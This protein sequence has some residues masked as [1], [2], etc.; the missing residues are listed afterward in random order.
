MGKRIVGDELNGTGQYGRTYTEPE[1]T[2][3][4]IRGTFRAYIDER[5]RY[6]ARPSVP[7]SPVEG[8][9]LKQKYRG[10]Y[11]G[12]AYKRCRFGCR[13]DGGNLTRVYYPDGCWVYP[14]DT[15]QWLCPQHTIK[16]LQNNE[17]YTME[18][19]LHDEETR[20]I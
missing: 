5:S 12:P 16:G 8:D 17:G 18:G 1:R 13:C 4:S 7:L 6:Q 20:S 3:P 9:E 19:F 15:D 11:R 2:A 10:R 14:H